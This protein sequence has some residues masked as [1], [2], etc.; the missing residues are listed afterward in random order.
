MHASPRIGADSQGLHTSE[1]KM[2]L[3]WAVSKARHGKGSR[4]VAKHQEPA[5]ATNNGSAEDVD[6]HPT[7]S[8][9]ILLG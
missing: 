6:Q 3:L 8:Q 4:G 2:R 7:A 9:A 1:L 5:S